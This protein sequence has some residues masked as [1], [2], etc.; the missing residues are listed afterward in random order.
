MEI[1]WTTDGVLAGEFVQLAEITKVICLATLYFL[2][3]EKLIHPY[4]LY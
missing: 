1:R 3:G 4:R 2:A